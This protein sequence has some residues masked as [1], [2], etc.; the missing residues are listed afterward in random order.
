[1]AHPLIPQRPSVWP[2][3]HSVR[4]TAAITIVTTAG[5]STLVPQRGR[6][7]T[8]GAL[9]ACGTSQSGREPSPRCAVAIA[10]GWQLTLLVWS[11][12]TRGKRAGHRTGSSSSGCKDR[13]ARLP[14]LP[15]RMLVLSPHSNVAVSPHAATSGCRPGASQ[16]LDDVFSAPRNARPT[17]DQSPVGIGMQKIANPTRDERAGA[18]AVELAVCLPMILILTLA[19]LQAC[20]MFYLRQTLSV[21]AY[22]GIRRAVDYQTST[23][24]VE[25]ACDRILTS[26]NVSG[27][28]VTISPS[29]YTSAAR[30][31]WI[32]VRVSAP[33][34]TN[35]PLRG[36]FYEDR[37]L[38]G[39]ATFMKEF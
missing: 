24:D 31:S 25:A 18:A 33:C 39:S 13:K 7:F 20:S 2:F 23:A 32:T 4:T 14:D 22:E 17:F 9:E 38:T 5:H 27:A 30:E 8:R 6:T 28:T 11:V 21:A 26:R 29:D 3:G 19:T 16:H 37:S 10:A 36:W 35:S 12:A 1:M 15:L 34:N